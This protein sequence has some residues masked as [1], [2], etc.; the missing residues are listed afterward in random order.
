METQPRYTVAD[1]P[2][3]WRHVWIVSVASLGQLIGTAL[4]T[5]VG[6]II[7]MLQILSHPELPSWL[8]GLLGAAD[9]IGIAVGAVI[10]GKLSDRWGYLLFFRICPVIMLVFSL[11]AIFVP[12]V[13]VLLICLF[14]IGFAIGGEYSLDSDYISELMPDKWAS[15]M[16]GVAKASSAF[17]NIIVAGVC[18]LLI[19]HWQ[20]AET[21]PRLMWLIAICAAVM[22]LSRIYFAGSPKWLLEKGRVDEAQKAVK[23]FLGDN[24]DISPENIA[25]A[26]AAE[27]ERKK[28][29][30]EKIGTTVPKQSLW[31]FVR[32][33]PLQV[34]LS[35]I[36]WACEGLGV[37]GIGIFLP[38]LVMALGL[39][40]FT[41]GEAEILHVASS[42]EVTFWISCLI[43]PGFIIGLLLLRKVYD[44]KLLYVGFFVCAAS[45]LVLMFGYQYKWAA[46]VSIVAFMAFE[47]FLNIGPHL[48]TY[49]LPP[50][51]Y[52]VAT[53]SLGSGIAACLGKVG[54][55]LAVFFI[56]VLLDAGGVSLV[57]IVSTAVMLTGGIVTLWAGPKVLPKKKELN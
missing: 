36:P 53:R 24:V 44:I 4:A 22:F 3:G 14:M 19:V 7:P 57:L 54:A 13:T 28:L 10:L 15:T 43:L 52:P 18:Y 26:E 51:I 2:F 17:G 38:I 21:W 45:L 48:V 55:V 32:Q 33:N 5:V 27:A 47:L 34:I 1:M 25:K 40:H 35:G 20:R 12:N 46:W 31:S 8:Q 42:V 23:F 56:P 49:V 41:P 30:S 29:A 11:V 37:Y 9:L 16:V 50:Q 39:E 6:I